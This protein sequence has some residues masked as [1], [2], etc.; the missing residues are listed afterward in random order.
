M[1]MS[2][3]S[4]AR[5]SSYVVSGQLAKKNTGYNVGMSMVWES[6]VLSWARVFTAK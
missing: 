2:R 4:A 3:D 5:Y 1:H 6:L